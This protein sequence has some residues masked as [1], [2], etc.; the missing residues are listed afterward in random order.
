MRKKGKRAKPRRLI[1]ALC[2]L[3]LVTVS[4]SA[5]ES[6]TTTSTQESTTYEA[7]RRRDR[8]VQKID[9]AITFTTQVWELYKQVYVYPGQQQTSE[10]VSSTP[11]WAMRSNATQ[12]YSQPRTI[13]YMPRPVD[14]RSFGTVRPY[15]PRST[16]RIYPARTVR[17]RS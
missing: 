1:A 6:T 11:A 9:R 16:N 15:V 3:L 8:I 12:R 7:P 13:R 4:A 5:Q 10:T 17:G 2:F 14:I